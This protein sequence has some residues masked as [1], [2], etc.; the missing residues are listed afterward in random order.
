MKPLDD[1]YRERLNRLST[2][3][4]SD[5]LDA[6]RLSGATYGV[7][8]MWE[9][10]GKVVGRAVTVRLMAAGLAKSKHHL[11]IRA[12][13]AAGGG[14]VILIDNGGRLD[15]SCWGGILSNAAKMKEI[16]GVVIDGACRDLDD[17]VEADLPVYARGSVVARI[18]RCNSAGCRCGRAILWSQIEAAW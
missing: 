7:R 5:A 15:T 2:T 11:G 8:P 13:G 3:N 17:C 14:D 12:I 1:K 4:V 6:L 9:S 10:A 16:A 18:S